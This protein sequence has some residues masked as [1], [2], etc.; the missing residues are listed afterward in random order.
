MKNQNPVFIAI[1]FALAFALAPVIQAAR[2]GG[3]PD[4][5]SAGATHQPSVEGEQ[6]PV[7]TINSA[8][9]VLRGK[10]GS[11]ILEMKP[12][13]AFGGMYV[14]F[15]ISGTAVAGVDYVAFLS[16]AYIGHSG[17]AVISSATSLE[18]SAG[19]SR[20]A[21]GV[22]RRWQRNWGFVLPCFTAGRSWSAP[23]MFRPTSQSPS[24]ASTHSKLR[25]GVYG[26]KTPN[27]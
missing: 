3:G 14:N 17:Y 19:S 13:L 10:T 12:A 21:A 9:N 6:L 23:P 22:L 20:P 24:A 18:T 25:S 1:V 4:P 15:K 8:G 5:T 27:F 16:P 7:I 2:P 26:P 11:F